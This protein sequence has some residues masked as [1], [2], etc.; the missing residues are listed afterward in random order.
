MFAPK[1][2]ACIKLTTLDAATV[3]RCINIRMQRKKP[4]RKVQRLRR[5]DATEWRRKCARWAQDHRQQIETA[6]ATM[7][8]ALGDRE[9]DI[10]E[11]LFVLANL[12][13]GDWPARI[14]A[15]ALA[16]CEAGPEVVVDSTQPP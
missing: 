1:A 11:P 7:P 5:Y 14:K 6:T 8:D 15:A 16:L 3:S 10:Y 12:A 13:G 4:G 9:Q 2:L